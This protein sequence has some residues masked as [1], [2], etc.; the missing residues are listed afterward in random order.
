ML[1][2]VTTQ[3][4]VLPTDTAINLLPS[5]F[6]WAIKW[7]ALADLLSIE[8]EAKDAARAA[9][10]EQRYQQGVE[11]CRMAATALQVY[12]GGV[13]IPFKAVEDL[14]RWEN[15]WQNVAPG[16]PQA[17]GIAGLSMFALQPTPDQAYQMSIDAVCSATIP[18]LNGDYLQ[19]GPEELEA[20]YGYAQHIATF[21]KGGEEFSDTMPLLENFMKAAALRN[22]RLTNASSF[23]GLLVSKE[24][25]AEAMRPRVSGEEAGGNQ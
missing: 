25:R 16:Y 20:I 19:I 23:M 18:V 12:Y 9:Y 6:G 21:K 5:D 15:G 7:G 10:C 24:S 11:A 17:V 22:A 13:Q 4:A 3:I 1:Y 2:T 14:D 8:S